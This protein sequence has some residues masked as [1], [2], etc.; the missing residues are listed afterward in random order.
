MSINQNTRPRFAP[1]NITATTETVRHRRPRGG[2][3]DVPL[4]RGHHH[5][6]VKASLR[7][8]ARVTLRN[9]LR[10]GGPEA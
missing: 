4:L 2:H 1:V 9:Y 6:V 7:L 3:R 5:E 10:E 8:E